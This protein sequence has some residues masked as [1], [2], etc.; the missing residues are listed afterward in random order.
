MS[1]KPPRIIPPSD[2]SPE[3]VDLVEQIQRELEQI[4]A[5]FT[6]HPSLQLEELH[7]VPE[8]PRTGL[9]VLADG[10]DWNPG[11][12]AGFYGYYGGSWVKLG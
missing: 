8:K 5:R 1:Y 4:G 6:T 11:S 7:A 2:A 9:I 12:G 3:V 10:T